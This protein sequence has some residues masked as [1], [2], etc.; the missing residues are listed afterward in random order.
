MT[1]EHSNHT[2]MLAQYRRVVFITGCSSG[3]GK[4]AVSLFLKKGWHVI[5]TM[6]N[7]QDRKHLFDLELTQFKDQLHLFSL[8]VTSQKDISSASDYIRNH[9]NNRVDCLINNAG[10]GLFGALE[11][12]TEDQLRHQFE[13]NFFGV[14]HLTQALLPSIRNA[15]GKII[16]VSSVLG[17]IAM[18]LTS[19]YC[20]SKYAL[21]GLTESLYYE[22]KP[23]GVQVAL[24]EP[25]AFRTRFDEAVNWGQ[26]CFSDSSPYQL[27]SLKY[28][29]FRGKLSSP[30]KSSKPEEV[31]KT[32]VRLA[33]MKKIPFRVRCGVDAKIA[34][35][36]KRILP[37]GAFLETLKIAYKNSYFDQK[38]GD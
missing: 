24:V 4:L 3:F 2:K 6:R 38:R 15:K 13:V 33:E 31:A 17:F 25:G 8:D 14:T 22:L 28:R 1:A 16:N 5:A 36:L 34:F 21:E 7:A 18:P 35:R 30:R 9:F 11:D 32:F 29:K 20:A 27:L 37:E 19:A 23:F 26:N 10:F 12:I